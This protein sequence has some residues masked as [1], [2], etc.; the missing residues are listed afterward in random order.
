ML[1]TSCLFLARDFATFG[2]VRG[3]LIGTGEQSRPPDATMIRGVD[4]EI[5]IVERRGYA[6]ERGAP[7]ISRAP[8]QKPELPPALGR[9]GDAL[10]RD[11]NRAPVG[12][13]VSQG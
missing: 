2:T 12:S 13:A 3:L 7:G 9:R 8:I 11:L 4:I 10:D 6:L 5:W 1:D